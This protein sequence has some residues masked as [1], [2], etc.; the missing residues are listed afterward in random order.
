LRLP[1]SLVTESQE[2]LVCG[3]CGRAVAPTSSYVKWWLEGSSPSGYPVV[4]CPPHISDWALRQTIG[5][6]KAAYKWRKEGIEEDRKHRLQESL[7][8][9]FFNP[10]DQ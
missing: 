6:T 9:P 7:F 10:N 1:K 8:E 2:P 5:R 4:R 3:K